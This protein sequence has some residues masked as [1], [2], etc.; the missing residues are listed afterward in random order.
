[1]Y[2]FHLVP[3]TSYQYLSAKAGV[4]NVEGLPSGCLWRSGLRT[5]EFQSLTWVECWHMAFGRYAQNY[6]S[7]HKRRKRVSYLLGSFAVLSKDEIPQTKKDADSMP[8][9]LERHRTVRAGESSAIR[10]SGG[11][12]QNNW[13]GMFSLHSSWSDSGST[14]HQGL[15]W[16]IAIRAVES[17]AHCSAQGNRANHVWDRSPQSFYV[18][19]SDIKKSR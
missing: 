5:S 17:R 10:T 13:A 7:K 8:K 1:M 6:Q 14:G 9:M 16:H 12:S 11:L 2:S 18:T 15:M 3:P 4:H 19:L